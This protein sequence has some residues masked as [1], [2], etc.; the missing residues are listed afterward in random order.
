M[1]TGSWK[2]TPFQDEQL[3]GFILPMI[4]DLISG[5]GFFLIPVGNAPKRSL[6]G[7]LLFLTS[8]DVKGQEKGDLRISA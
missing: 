4:Y 7:I 5:I 2:S 1:W 6:G 3:Y 8:L